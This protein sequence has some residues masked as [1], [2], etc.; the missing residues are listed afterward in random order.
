MRTPGRW[1]G[2]G[3]GWR[4]ALAG[5]LLAALLAGCVGGVS[6]RSG[7]WVDPTLLESRL[8]VGVSTR[9][10][11]RR[12]LGVPL[13]G[14]AA[15]LPGMPGP[16]TQWYYYYEQGTLEDDRRQFLFVFF[17]GDAYDGYLWFSSLLEGT[18]PAP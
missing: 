6:I 14:G 7:R 4:P 17:D 5:L 1:A 10:D 13:G 15:L 16:R 18:L 9:A 12:V 2:P 3:R 8:T 11:V